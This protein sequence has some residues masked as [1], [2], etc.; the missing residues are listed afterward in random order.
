M[1]RVLLVIQYD[2]TDYHG[3]QQQPGLPTIQ[4]ELELALIRVLGEEVALTAAGR[5]DAGVHGLGQAVAFDTNNPIPMGNLA[6]ALNDALPQA[7]AIVS[8][9]QVD[10]EFHPRY[11]AKG[12]LYSYR[13]LNREL[14]SPFINRY[15]WHVPEPLDVGMMRAAAEKLVGTH[16][17]AAFRTS[18]GSAEDTVRTMRR[19]EVESEGELVEVRL[20][21]DGFLY[22]MVRIIVGTLVQV[23]RG[24]L[25]PEE[26]GRILDARDRRRAGPTAPPQGLSL[27]KVIY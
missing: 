20:E 25:S 17:F 16:D 24:E 23:G 15:A 13:I 21:A 1:R 4:R 6:R 2:G 18:G 10:A 7:I 8:A 26:V 22:M 3:F 14:P 27:V 9:E 5:T 12:K 19:L 11:D